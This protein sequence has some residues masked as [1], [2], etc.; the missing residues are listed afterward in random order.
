MPAAAGVFA[1][2]DIDSMFGA[3]TPVEPVEDE[4]KADL[5]KGFGL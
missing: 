4:T 1:G 3:F 5:L 2:A